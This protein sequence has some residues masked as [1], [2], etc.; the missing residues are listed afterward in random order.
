MEYLPAAEFL[1]QTRSLKVV[2]VRSPSEF[3]TGHIPGAINIPL[4]ADD[5]R[6]IVGTIYKQKGQQSAIDKGMEFVEP[7]MAA[8]ADS[9]KSVA[10]NGK[11]GVYCW[12]GGM[13]SNRTAWWFEENGLQCSVLTGGYKAYRNWALEDFGNLEKLVV[14]DGPTGSGKT[15]ILHALRNA[16]EQIL[17]LEGFANHKGSAFGGIGLGKQP[18]SQQFQNDLHHELGRLDAGKRIWVE[19]E[20]M[21]IGKVYLPQPLWQKMR[22]SA[23]I[24]IELPLSL[25][26]ERLVNDYGSAPVDLLESSIRKLQQK[27]GGQHMKAVLELLDENKLDEVAKVLLNYYDKRYSY[28]QEKYLERKPL[29]LE[30][31]SNDANENALRLISL[32]N[33]NG[34]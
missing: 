12:R 1:E 11:V 29:I 3:S 30:L 15:E 32:A 28:S 18:G 16:G 4:F 26:V 31:N 5:E 8:L 14:L 7:K 2:D 9:A 34:L 20:G 21:T 22:A 13:R 27:L 24:A 10:V 25:R 23:A 19:R 6:A 33:E 17:D